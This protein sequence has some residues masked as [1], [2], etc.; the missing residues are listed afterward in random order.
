MVAASVSLSATSA[1]KDDIR[2]ARKRV[3]GAASVI[4]SCI[5]LKLGDRVSQSRCHNIG[6]AQGVSAQKVAFIVPQPAP[7]AV[8]LPLSYPFW[9]RGTHSRQRF[10]SH[11]SRPPLSVS[12]SMTSFAHYDS[13]RR[14]HRTGGNPE[15]GHGWSAV[16]LSAGPFIPTYL[17]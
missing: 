8:L 2:R 13:N 4:R 9:K 12:L 14:R 15:A 1:G 3:R 17:R 11:I 5:L 16:L 10:L 7:L 6:N